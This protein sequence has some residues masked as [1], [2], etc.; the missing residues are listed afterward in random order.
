MVASHKA[1]QSARERVA[2]CRPGMIEKAKRAEAKASIEYAKVVES[3]RSLAGTGS[4][5]VSILLP[6]K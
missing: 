3:G 6:V 2:A 4:G 5:K 1:I